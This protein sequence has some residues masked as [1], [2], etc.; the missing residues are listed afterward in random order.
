MQPDPN[1]K[2]DTTYVTGSNTKIQYGDTITLHLTIHAKY[3]AF[4]VSLPVTHSNNKNSGIRTVLEVNLLKESF[5]AKALQNIKIFM[6]IV[7][8]YIEYSIF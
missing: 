3:S 6:V 8:K 4:Y 1:V 7:Q 2:V 5:S